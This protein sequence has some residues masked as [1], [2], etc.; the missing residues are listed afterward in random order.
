M[1][2]TQFPRPT[3]PVKITPPLSRERD[4]TPNNREHY[5]ASPG[6]TSALHF[7][8]ELPQTC[9]YLKLLL[10]G[11]IH[12]N[13]GPVQ[14]QSLTAKAAATSLPPRRQHYRS[15]KNNLPFCTTTPPQ[16]Q[17]GHLRPGLMFTE[18]VHT[19]LQT[20]EHNHLSPQLISD[21]TG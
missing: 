1:S 6:K 13:P 5:T 16:R 11:D 9:R 8:A 4:T 20:A 19:N 18:N 17:F 3:W 21:L 12:P 10:S 7:S 2:T 14:G 15:V